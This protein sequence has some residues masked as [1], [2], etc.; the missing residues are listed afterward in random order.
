MWSITPNTH[1]IRVG[2]DI[3]CLVASVK[4]LRYYEK[5]AQWSGHTGNATESNFRVF[6]DLKASPEL[7]FISIGPSGS[8]PGDSRNQLEYECI[9]VYVLFLDP[10]TQKERKEKYQYQQ[11]A[12]KKVGNHFSLPLLIYPWPRAVLQQLKIHC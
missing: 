1:S 4:K 3:S 12:T 11:S 10:R 9:L 5:T 2:R 7:L 8:P 6:I